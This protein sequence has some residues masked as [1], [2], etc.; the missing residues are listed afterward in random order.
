MKTNVN[1]LFTNFTNDLFV[2]L[3][4]VSEFVN[5]LY[6]YIYHINI[7]TDFLIQ[8]II[9]KL[10]CLESDSFLIRGNQHFY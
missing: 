9:L 4:Y 2:F 7:K 8:A 6:I 10:K 5:K 3:K 1:T